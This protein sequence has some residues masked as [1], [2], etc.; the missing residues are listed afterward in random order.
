M[1]YSKE[2]L[3]SD[4]FSMQDSAYRDFHAALIPNIS[5]EKIIG[6]R[7]P[8]LRSFAK[9][10]AKT[11]AA[12]GFL[13]SLPHTYYEENNLHGFIIETFKDYDRVIS[14]LDA[15]LPYVDN[16][17]TCD[18]LS[19]V[20]LRAHTKELTYEIRRW[21]ASGKTYTVRFAIGLLMKYYFDEN[22]SP[23]VLSTVASVKSDEYYVNMM[24]AWFF[25]TALA[26]RYDCAL[27]YLTEKKLDIWVHNKAIRKAVESNRITKERKEYL[28]TLKRDKAL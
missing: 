5:R 16:W 21:I 4:L 19:P 17:A 10:F 9:K 3:I 8:L 7:V 24:I 22:F 25:A 26:K 14:E 12:D 15:F 18:T 23:E 28:K 2:K 6:V 27:S 13:A 1:P 11:D 20:V